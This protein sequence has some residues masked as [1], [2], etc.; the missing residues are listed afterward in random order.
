VALWATTTPFK[1][2]EISATSNEVE[3]LDIV[4]KELISGKRSNI[5][6]IH[7]I[8]NIASLVGLRPAA[9]AGFDILPPDPQAARGGYGFFN[10]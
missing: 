8:K 6:C 3:A 5:Q 9:A 2:R 7:L 10:A 1:R 4:E